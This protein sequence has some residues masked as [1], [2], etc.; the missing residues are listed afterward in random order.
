[1]ALVNKYTIGNRLHDQK[2]IFKY[3]YP[4]G[5]SEIIVMTEYKILTFVT[6]KQNN[7]HIR[8]Y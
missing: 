2:T 7:K 8:G 3:F 5:K 6:Q 1:M 4:A